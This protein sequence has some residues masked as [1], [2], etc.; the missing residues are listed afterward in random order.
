MLEDGAWISDLAHCPGKC[1]S[2]RE[3][4]EEE[5]GPC[6]KIRSKRKRGNDWRKNMWEESVLYGGRRGEEKGREGGRRGRT[7]GVK[8]KAGVS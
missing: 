5:E 1:S 2:E 3:E 6:R 4:E 7:G 8:E